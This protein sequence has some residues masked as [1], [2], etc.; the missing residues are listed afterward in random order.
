MVP[1]A[2]RRPSL[3]PAAVTAAVVSAALSAWT[4]RMSAL[5]PGLL[6]ASVIAAA[7][8]AALTL[9]IPGWDEESPPYRAWLSFR[10]AMLVSALGLALPLSVQMGPRPDETLFLLR[11]ILALP[12][13]FVAI[14][15]IAPVFWLVAKRFAAAADRPPGPHHIR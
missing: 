3:L 10:L 1:P 15:V 12:V 5:T 11:I 6:L 9:F 13:Q 4:L 7:L 14:A 8:S 2:N